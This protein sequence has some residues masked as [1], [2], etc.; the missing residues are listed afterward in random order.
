MW[1]V[2]CFLL[3]LIGILELRTMLCSFAR[4]LTVSFKTLLPHRTR[5]TLYLSGSLGLA[6]AQEHILIINKTIMN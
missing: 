4:C 6:V 2:K 3:G 5:T 1:G